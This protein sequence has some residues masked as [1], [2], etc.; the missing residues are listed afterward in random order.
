M[1]GPPVYAPP[2]MELTGGSTLPSGGISASSYPP[3]VAAIQQTERYLKIKNNTGDR[4]RVYVQ[5][6][7][8]TAG[9]EWAWLPD[10]PG[11]NLAPFGYDFEPGEEAV[12]GNAQGNLAAHCVRVWARSPSG[13][14]W[15]DYRNAD[16]YLV[17]EQDANG[18]RYYV[19]PDRETF[20][21]SFDR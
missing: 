9:G 16:L 19:A 11:E 1:S 6:Y 15:A 17:P 8:M 12:L 5:H 10:R 2:V 4:L 14:E 3:T 13:L 21:F 7:S 20:T 18:D